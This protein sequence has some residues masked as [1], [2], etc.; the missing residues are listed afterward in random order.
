MGIKPDKH[1]MGFASI[2]FFL[3]ISVMIS[4]NFSL[5]TQKAL[6]Y[7]L[8]HLPKEERN[9]VVFDCDGT[10]LYGDSQLVLTVDQI[11]YLNFAFSPEEL[12]HIFIAGNE[13]V[14]SKE[15][16]GISIPTLLRAV[17][18]DYE[19]LYSKGF[20]SKDIE[21]YKRINEWKDNG[22]FCD[23]KIRLHHLLDKVYS[24]WGYEASSYIVYSLFK[25][26]TREEYL[27]LAS[28]SHK[29]HSEISGLMKES[30]VH[31]ETKETV[32]FY[33]GLHPIVEMRELIDTL[34]E[35]GIDVYVASASPELTVKDAL[36]KFGYSPRIKIF[37]IEN[38]IDKKGRITAY[39]EKENH[40]S[41]IQY[42]KVATIEKY[43]APL[44]EGRSPLMVFGDSEGDVAMLTHFKD[45][46]LSF[47]FD[48]GSPSKTDTMKE[49]AREQEKKDFDGEK[50]FLLEGKNSPKA[51]LTG[52]S[53]SI[54]FD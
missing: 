21:N 36:N 4:K 41:P 13:D 42:G 39:K 19:Y 22:I 11:E 12:S 50:I 35:K 45:S 49:M 51:I 34:L 26:F 37:G 6:S 46:K 18:E 17:L 3:I 27:L 2:P 5:R 28:M 54:C 44:Y 20:V 40:A 7:L 53:K 1:L 43:I 9:Y 16:N 24:L 47:L 15:E 30:Y 29:R 23:F 25:G 31:P 33:K 48:D 38:K 32:S 14:W 10:L 8:G 52:T